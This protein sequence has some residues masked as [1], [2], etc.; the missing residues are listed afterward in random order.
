MTPEL[1]NSFFY[2]AKYHSDA[3]VSEVVSELAQVFVCGTI[4]WYTMQIFLDCI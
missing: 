2:H 3:E 1:T 4:P